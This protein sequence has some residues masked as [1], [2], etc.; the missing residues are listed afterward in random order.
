MNGRE[1]A[2]THE[3][4]VFGE[5]ETIELPVASFVRL[6]QVRSGMNPDLPELK[7]SIGTR[8][9]LN[10]IDAARMSEAQL[11]AYIDFVNR[12]WKTDVS[13]DDFV[14]HKQPD[15]NY[16]VVIAGHTRTEAVFQLQ[17]EDEAGF[18]YAMIAKVH[19]IST[20]EEI[21][22]LQLDE[23]IHSKPAQEQRAIAIVETYRHG[24]ESGMWANKTEFLK[25]SKGKFSRRIL[26]EAM[27]FAQLPPQAIDFV[28]SGKLS[29]NAAVAL[30]LASETVM[31]YTAMKLGY[32]M[33]IPLEA[34]EEFEQAYR[35]E[36]GLMIARISNRNLNG[37]AAKKF[38]G[39]QVG[40]MQAQITRSQ[41]PGNQEELFAFD[42][43]SPREQADAYLRQLQKEYRAALRDMQ[44][45]SIEAVTGA[46]NL[47]RRL[48]G[49]EGLDIFEQ[50]EEV[51]RRQLGVR[52]VG[53]ASAA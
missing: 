51:R 37:T 42:L 23:N 25:Q 41:E 30:G 24:L 2:P 26:D 8:G 40:H 21:I 28:F 14:M 46:L 12:T 9:L 22:A 20:P 16:Y 11:A 19:P 45:S 44:Q 50:E 18:E 52:A 32:E 6:P 17:E 31:D 3:R 36:V 53:I 4:K 48:V 29:Y 15:E 39:G 34:T 10:Q 13:L 47:H 7:Q 27:G 33:A 43:I 35:Q 5:Y 1:T 38:I 49:S